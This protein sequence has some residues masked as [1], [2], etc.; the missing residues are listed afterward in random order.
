MK[1]ALIL[2]FVLVAC[3]VVAQAQRDAPVWH[4]FLPRISLFDERKTLDFE[5]TFKKAGGPKEQSSHS[6]VYVLAYLE[7]DESRIQELADNK[8]L[9]T[10]SDK[11]DELLLDV[12]VNEGLVALLETKVA[13]ES[14]DPV[15][16]SPRSGRASRGS[17]CY[18]FEF[19]FDNRKL[20]ETIGKLKSFDHTN[21]VDSAYRYYND[22]FKLMIFVPVNDCRYATKIPR[23]Q[24]EFHDFAHFMDSETI[25]QYFKPLPYRFQFKPLDDEGIVLL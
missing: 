3:P 1:T 7:K 6:Q 25:I 16:I 12:L 14:E 9:T 2:F 10:K 20:F 13:K 21:F 8:E 15:V 24:R 18:D 11:K 17:S 4:S 22:K 19:S 23:Q 5:I